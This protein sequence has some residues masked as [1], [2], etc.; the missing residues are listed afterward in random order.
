MLVLLANIKA[1]W[2]G[3]TALVVLSDSTNITSANGAAS[4]PK[5]Q[6]TDLLHCFNDA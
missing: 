1:S 4:G 2:E 5:E 3:H 6:V